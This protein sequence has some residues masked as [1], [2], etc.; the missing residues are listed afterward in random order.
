MKES[1]VIRGGR[2]K[3]FQGMSVILPHPEHVTRRWV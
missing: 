3:S 1:T 2:S